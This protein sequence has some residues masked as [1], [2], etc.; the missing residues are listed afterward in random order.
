M[1]EGVPPLLPTSATA[2]FIGRVG[3]EDG[4][5]GSR[6]ESAPPPALVG[7][8]QIPR[9][10]IRDFPKSLLSYREIVTPEGRGL[11]PP[12]GS[13]CPSEGVPEGVHHRRPRVQA[14]RR[15]RG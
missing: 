6:S 15:P 11:P 2:S 14:N 10:L 8:H 12:S 1:D 7:P 13:V 3:W 5:G 9:E 4:G